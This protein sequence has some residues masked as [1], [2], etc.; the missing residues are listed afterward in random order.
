MV[1]NL[2]DR[3]HPTRFSALYRASMSILQRNCDFS[4][5]QNREGLL[6]LQEIKASI[7]IHAHHREQTE[8]SKQNE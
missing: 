2:T 1:F 3:C 6:L 5:E 7:G 8:Q 4:S